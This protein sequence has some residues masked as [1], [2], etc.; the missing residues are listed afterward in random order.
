MWGC[1]ER[2]GKQG[3]K[4]PIS[5]GETH[6]PSAAGAATVLCLPA[7]GSCLMSDQPLAPL[8]WNPGAPVWAGVHEYPWLDLF[9]LP[10]KHQH[11]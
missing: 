9:C 5:L 4:G 1:D 11:I 8:W 10:P 7:R 3:W 2:H 6:T